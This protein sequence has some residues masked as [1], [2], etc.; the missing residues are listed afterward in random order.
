MDMT[1]CIVDYPLSHQ[2]LRIRPLLFIWNFEIILAA[3]MKI[4][5]C[6]SSRNPIYFFRGGIPEAGRDAIPG[7]ILLLFADGN[8]LR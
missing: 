7:E 4:S 8:V 6:P 3:L 2:T 1:F 5:P